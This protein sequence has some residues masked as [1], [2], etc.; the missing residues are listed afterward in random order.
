[1][2]KFT[3]A[4]I[5]TGAGIIL[6]LGGAGTLA[7][8]NDSAAVDGGAITAG[9]LGIDSAGAGKWYD[10]SS[11]GALT[12]PETQGVDITAAVAGGTFLVVPGDKL[13]YVESFTVEATGEHLVASIAADAASIDKGTWGADL[14][15]ST[16]LSIGGTTVSSITDDNDGDTVKVLVTL[17]FALNS[18]VGVDAPVNNTSQGTTVDLED[19]A[20]V[21]TQNH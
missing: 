16:A 8:W 18:S 20:I 21:V 7:Y 11:V 6:L 15:A 17:A 19:L 1:M 3:K 5:A 13:V 12:D 2:N 4:S 10:V 14:S 9:T